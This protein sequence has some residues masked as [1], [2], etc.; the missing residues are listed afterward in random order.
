MM[1][2]DVK[3]PVKQTIRYQHGCL[4]LLLRSHVTFPHTFFSFFSS[5]HTLL[6]NYIY[7][8]TSY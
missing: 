1:T 6:Y 4:K 5:V 2:N 8:Q 3:L 7:F